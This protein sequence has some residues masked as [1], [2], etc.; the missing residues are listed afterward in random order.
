MELNKTF[1][2][3]APLKKVLA[4]IRNP[5][6]IEESENSRDALGVQITDLKKTKTEHQF[7]IHVDSYA[8]GLKGVDKNTVEHNVTTVSWD[9]KAARGT[10]VWKGG[11]GHA[12]KVNVTGSY[13]LSERGEKTDIT[14]RV[15]IDISVP[16]IGRLIAKKVAAEFEKQWPPYVSRVERWAQKA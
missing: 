11:G 12:D 9:L 10:W 14:L 15:D 13:L 8:V 1:S 5:E 3:G 7:E 6:M 16:V 2:V 4:S